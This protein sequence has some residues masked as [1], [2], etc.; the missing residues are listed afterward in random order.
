MLCMT[1]HYKA[2]ATQLLVSG[3][4]RRGLQGTLPR[5]SGHLTAML[6]QQRRQRL[7]KQL[8]RGEQS[9]LQPQWIAC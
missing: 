9:K 3:P 6:A 1:L 8:G 4:P 2:Y 5:M 7:I